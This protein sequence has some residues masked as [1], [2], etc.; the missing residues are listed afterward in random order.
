VHVHHADERGNGQILGPDPYFDELFC[1]AA[2]RRIVSCERIVDTAALGELGCI[3]TLQLNRTLVDGVVEAPFGAHPTACSPG[4]GIDLE[5]LKVYAA[6]AAGAEAWAGYR[7]RYVD[8][9][10]EAYIEAV[11][12]APRL[13]TIPPPI[14]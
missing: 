5:H 14:F 7:Q 1:G 11:G 8:I 3:H 10:H 4:Y 9:G 13:T 6:A 12:G 2:A